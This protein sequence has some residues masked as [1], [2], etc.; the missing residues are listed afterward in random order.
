MGWDLSLG[1]ERYRELFGAKIFAIWLP[2]LEPNHP[3]ELKKIYLVCLF[4]DTH[5]SQFTFT[6]HN[7][8]SQFTIHNS[9]APIS[10]VLHLVVR[11]K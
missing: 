7:S 4:Q 6:I 1:E 5:N 8:H 2:C 10:R 3:L 11:P 9:H